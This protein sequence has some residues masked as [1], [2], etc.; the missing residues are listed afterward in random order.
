[1][2]FPEPVIRVAIEPKTK[3]GNEKMGI[4]LAKLAEED[5]NLQDLH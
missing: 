5:P 2:K 1:M 3:A 4:A